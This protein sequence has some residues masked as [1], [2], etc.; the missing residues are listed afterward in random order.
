MSASLEQL[1][2][3]ARI[4]LVL[5]RIEKDSTVIEEVIRNVDN[6]IRSI[7]FNSIFVLGELGEKSGEKA[8]HKITDYLDD[9]DW[10][11]RRE[12]ER[13]LGKIG[14]TAST[15]INELTKCCSED[16]D[17][18]RLAGVTSLGKIGHV[19]E[20]VLKAL[21]DALKDKNEQ[22]RIE[23]AKAL[24]L[25]GSEAYEVIPDLMRSISDPS[26]AVRTSSARAMSSIGKDSVKAIPT[27]INALDD[28]DWRVRYHVV[29][30]FK[31]I[32]EASAPYLLNILNH[33]NRLVRK[34]AV[35]ALGEL[36]LKTPNIIDNLSLMLKDPKEEVRGKAAN[37][38]RS[39]GKEAVPALI[40]AAKVAN[41]KMKVVIIS[42]IG[43]IGLEA[44]E[45]IPYLISLLAVN[46]K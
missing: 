15:S 22:V 29:N 19:T 33:S 46:K 14:K 24:G 32:G 17:S 20:E 1:L 36:G 31:Q 34:E 25:L 18:I 30:T 16:E 26:W 45:A 21:K 43:G 2:R 7:R 6:D 13:S 38:L 41:T 27:L 10:S 9:D 40:N 44:N 39:L 8:V 12:A 3:D 23:A 28:K 4:D 5:A 42:A 35:E 11:I 37:S